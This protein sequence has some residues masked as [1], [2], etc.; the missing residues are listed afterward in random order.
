MIMF[1]KIVPAQGTQNCGKPCLPT[2]AEKNVERTPRA[3]HCTDRA[4]TWTTVCGR[5]SSVDL[6]SVYANG[7]RT[8][9]YH[10]CK[11]TY[12]V[13]VSY[14]DIAYPTSYGM[15]LLDGQYPKSVSVTTWLPRWWNS[16]PGTMTYEPNAFNSGIFSRHPVIFAALFIQGKQGGDS[17]AKTRATA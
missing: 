1:S 3:A 12:Q 6:H 15:H 11:Y 9:T 16:K 4:Q 8:M 2:L 14:F 13:Y 10:Q 17:R 7:A 5:L